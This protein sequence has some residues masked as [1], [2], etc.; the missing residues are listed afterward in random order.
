MKNDPLY[1]QHVIIHFIEDDFMY[2]KYDE[3]RLVKD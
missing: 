3:I 1:S 2:T